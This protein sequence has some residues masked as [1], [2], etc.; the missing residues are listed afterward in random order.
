MKQF[1]WGGNAW[2]LVAI[3]VA[4]GSVA[5]VGFGTDSLI[6]LAAGGVIVWLFTEG[7]C[8]VNELAEAVEMEDSAVSHQLR[9]L[10]HLGLVARQERSA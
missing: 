8:N 5:L 2:H 9:V 10:R 7:D 1:A 4:A 6:E 3:G